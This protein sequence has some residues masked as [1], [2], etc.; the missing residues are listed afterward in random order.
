MREADYKAFLKFD[1]DWLHTGAS[2]FIGHI[3]AH[4]FLIDLDVPVTGQAAVAIAE[5]LTRVLRL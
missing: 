4:L 1:C 2:L 3:I 5:T